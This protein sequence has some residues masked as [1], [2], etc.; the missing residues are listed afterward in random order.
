MQNLDSVTIIV[1]S[2]SKEQ[3]IDWVNLHKKCFKSK[4]DKINQLFS[5]YELNDSRFT[6]VYIGKKLVVSYS[7]L[8]IEND[9]GIKVFL[10]TDTMSDGTF[11]GGSVFAA[12]KLYKHLET[13]G[14]KIV[15]GYPNKLIEKIRRYKLKWIH[16]T[17]MHLYIL[18]SFLLPKDIKPALRLNRPQTGFF[19]RPSQFA[20]IGRFRSGFSLLRLELSTYRPHPFAI[21]VSTLLGF[22][23]KKFYYL[24][25]D[26]KIN[27]EEMV[28]GSIVLNSKSIDVL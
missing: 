9:F 15:C 25:L 20:S 2:L 28:K 10:S 12:K 8:F 26:K 7:G 3:K 16:S 5:K 27:I 21:N 6:L 4:D 17:E 13:E 11:K 23:S 19:H 1:N 14:V 22:G 18:P 24:F